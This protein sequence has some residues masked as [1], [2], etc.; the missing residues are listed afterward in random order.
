MLFNHNDRQCINQGGQAMA[1]YDSLKDYIR[2]NHLDT[3]VEGVN[4]YIRT[5]SNVKLRINDL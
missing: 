2:L 4:D 5:S 3:I 1:Q